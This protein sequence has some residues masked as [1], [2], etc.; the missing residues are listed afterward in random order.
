MAVFDTKVCCLY[1]T[2]LKISVI[3]LYKRLVAQDDVVEEVSK[4]CEILKDAK[5][6]KQCQEVV[7]E[8]GPI[9]TVILQKTLRVLLFSYVISTDALGNTFFIFASFAETRLSTAVFGNGALR[10]R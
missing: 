3:I 4:M 10:N 5:I 1:V 9:V 7:K 8:N 2:C 6:I